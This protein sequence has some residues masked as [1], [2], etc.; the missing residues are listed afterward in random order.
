MTSRRRRRT[1]AEMDSIR[2]AIYEA[3]AAG[4]ILLFSTRRGRATARSGG[5]W[6]PNTTRLAELNLTVAFPTALIAGEA[7]REL[8]TPGRLIAN[9]LDATR[10]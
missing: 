3:L 1:K 6:G 4:A 8:Q 7:G 5:P 9:P 10:D 2:A